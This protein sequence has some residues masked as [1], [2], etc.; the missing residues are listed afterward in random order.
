MSDFAWVCNECGSEE[1]SS[2]VSEE[3]LDY[4]ACGRCGCPD[5]HKEPLSS[6]EQEKPTFQISMGLPGWVCPKCG[7]VY[8]PSTSECWRCNGSEITITN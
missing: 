2:S 1:Y 5:F 7:S 6:D 3:D 4:C 8:S